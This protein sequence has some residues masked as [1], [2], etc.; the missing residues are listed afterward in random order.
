MLNLAPVPRDRG[1]Q[2]S[3]S[4]KFAGWDLNLGLVCDDLEE[5]ESAGRTSAR[6][7]LITG[8]LRHVHGDKLHGVQSPHPAAGPVDNCAGG[9]RE[10]FLAA[11]FDALSAAWPLTAAQRGRL[12]PLTGAALSAGWSPAA[13]AEFTGARR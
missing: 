10:L 6:Q 2:P 3:S 5:A 12:A 7:A 13:L 11:V 9:M 8:R 4:C 1:G